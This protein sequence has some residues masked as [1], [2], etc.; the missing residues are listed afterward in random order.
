MA[1]HALVRRTALAVGAALLLPIGVAQAA[2]TDGTPGA[3]GI[4]DPYY[5]DYGNGG[6]DVDHYG[7]R[8]SYAPKTDRLAG[9]TRI[10]ATATQDLSRFNLDFVLPVRSVVVNGQDATFTQ[11]QHELVV[12]PE[13][14][15]ASG[16]PSQDA[17]GLPA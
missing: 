3:P 17:G 4:G 13:Q 7:I 11:G 14:T 8:V 5:A 16:A 2:P 1:S 9:R 15:V 10:D 12:T 6:Y